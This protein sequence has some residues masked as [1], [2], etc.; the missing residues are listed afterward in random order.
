MLL[1]RK[2]C[3]TKSL[4]KKTVR[5]HWMDAMPREKPVPW[6]YLDP[7]KSNPPRL[8][9][10]VNNIAIKVYYSMYVVPE[11]FRG[12]SYMSGRYLIQ[13]RYLGEEEKIVS[14]P[15]KFLTY[16]TGT[17][18]GRLW[19]IDVDLHSVRSLLEK[20]SSLKTESLKNVVCVEIGHLIKRRNY[21]TKHYELIQ[22][23]IKEYKDCIFWE[24]Y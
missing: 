17:N 6:I 13:F 15:G 11:S 8:S 20:G 9:F 5:Q 12:C 18:T 2:N 14:S 16:F 23:I 19:E 4:R 3:L 7:K 1:T 24:I 10:D 21:R 22:S